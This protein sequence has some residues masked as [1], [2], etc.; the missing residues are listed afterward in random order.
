MY[1]FFLYV[2]DLLLSEITPRC[3]TLKLVQYNNFYRISWGNAHIEL[4]TCSKDLHCFLHLLVTINDLV[5]LEAKKSRISDNKK[6]SAQ[7][8]VVEDG[9]VLVELLRTSGITL[10][11]GE[12][13]NEIGMDLA[14]IPLSSIS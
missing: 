9:G 12:S 2:D 11:T 1:I 5:F 3:L 13:Q 14:F 4:F 7:D 8:G 6:P 10:K